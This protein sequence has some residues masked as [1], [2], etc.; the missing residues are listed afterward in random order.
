MADT[1]ADPE[2]LNRVNAVV[3]PIFSILAIL[4]TILP[5]RQFWISRNFPAF[6]IILVNDLLCLQYC[7]N[8]VIWRTD[9]INQWFN[10]YIYCDIQVA[11]RFPLTVSLAFSLLRLTRT[12]A[13]ALDGKHMDFVDTE[14]RMKRKLVLDILW[15]WTVPL[16][17][18]ALSFLIMSGRYDIQAVYGCLALFDNTWLSLLVHTIWFPYLMVHTLYYSCKFSKHCERG[19]GTDRIIVAII[20]RIF[21]HRRN[22]G[23][24]LRHTGSGMSDRRFLKLVILAL[25]LILVY[26]P[27]Q[28]FAFSNDLPL[29]PIENWTWNLHHAYSTEMHT[30]PWTVILFGI[31]KASFPIYQYYGWEPVAWDILM[32]LFYGLNW[33]TWDVIRGLA[34]K[35]GFAKIF[36]SLREPRQ[37]RQRPDTSSVFSEWLSNKMDIT[38]RILYW[39]EVSTWLNAIEDWVVVRKFLAWRER[40]A[41]G[42]SIWVKVKNLFK[43]N[44]TGSREATALEIELDILNLSS[45]LDSDV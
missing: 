39:L 38:G 2:D 24:A 1:A 9:N 11:T 30:V 15:C 31:G 34:A 4:C 45:G 27:C 18:T 17:Q 13:N 10:G 7:A 32:F 42:S 33:D 41:N 36:H 43:M 44:R 29:L 21:R 25:I 8:A 26:I 3:L 23:S 14:A 28:S 35:I 6:N 20:F 19:V 5:V 37:P 12:L 40:C 16:L 22:I